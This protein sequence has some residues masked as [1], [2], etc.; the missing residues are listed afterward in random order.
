MTQKISSFHFCTSALPIEH[1]KV[2]WRDV[3]HPFYQTSDQVED[4]IFEAK[5]SGY[6]FKNFLCINAEADPQ[7][8][9]SG[10]ERALKSGYDG[11]IVKLILEGHCDF[12]GDA[13]SIRNGAGG[14]T[15]LDMSREVIGIT[16]KIDTINL[17]IPRH[18]LSKHIVN[19]ESLHLQTL[20]QA[21]VMTRLLV[22][23][24]TMLRKEAKSITQNEILDVSKL[25]I[26]LVISALQ[27]HI[28]TANLAPP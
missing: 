15:I 2:A 18:V 4:A 24:M 9:Y 14:I 27:N 3:M 26:E 10:T 17:V 5:V 23:H 1:K 22:N 11:V 7:N 25:T 19:I 12:S 21:S 20:N 8:Y 6:F 13:S 16:P 28:K